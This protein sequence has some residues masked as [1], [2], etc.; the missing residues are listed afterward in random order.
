LWGSRSGGCGPCVHMRWCVLEGVGWGCLVFV[1]V[2]VC[3]HV[4][5]TCSTCTGLCGRHQELARSS[6]GVSKVKWRLAGAEQVGRCIC[7]V[8]WHVQAKC[9]NQTHM[10]QEHTHTYAT[11]ARTHTY[12]TRTHTNMPQEHA[13]TVKP[14]VR[15]ASVKPSVRRA[16]VYARGSRQRGK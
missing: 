7:F 16:E 8:L 13:R 5:A 14:S 4:H 15:R 2:C 6:G 12:A 11:R 1:H 9:R 3:T 10:P